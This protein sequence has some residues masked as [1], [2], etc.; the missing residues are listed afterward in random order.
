MPAAVRFATTTAGS[1]LG[2]RRRGLGT[3]VAGTTED[4]IGVET[5]AA[6][7]LAAANKARTLSAMAASLSPIFSICSRNITGLFRSRKTFKNAEE[8]PCVNGS[9]KFAVCGRKFIKYL[10]ILR[11]VNWWI[12]LDSSIRINPRRLAIKKHLVEIFTRSYKT[13]LF[14]Q[15]NIVKKPVTKQKRSKNE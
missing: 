8:K 2:S 3:G 9:Q 6:V 7:L 15:K 5:A 11:Y 12:F 4:A 14:G 13:V 10:R 1:A